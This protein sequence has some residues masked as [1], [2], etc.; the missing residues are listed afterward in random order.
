MFLKYCIYARSDVLTVVLLEDSGLLGY[1]AVSFGDHFPNILDKHSVFETSITSHPMTG[2]NIPADL[3]PV[4]VTP[5]L[6]PT[7]YHTLRCCNCSNVR[8]FTGN[9]NMSCSSK[10]FLCF[11]AMHIWKSWYKTGTRSFESWTSNSTR[12]AP[13]DA[14][15]FSDAIV[16]SRTSAHLQCRKSVVRYKM[17][18]NKQ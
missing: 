1:A 2:H 9:S 6:T 16:F 5:K 7:I 13:A 15:F 18:D 10:C 11:N 12:S 14:A 3:N 4:F 8:S 17:Y